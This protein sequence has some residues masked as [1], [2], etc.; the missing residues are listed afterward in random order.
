M[1]GGS[2]PASGRQRAPLGSFAFGKTDQSVARHDDGR[3]AVGL[4]PELRAMLPGPFV[5]GREIVF[6]DQ[7]GKSLAP[8]VADGKG[9]VAD[10]AG[11]GG[12]VRS[13]VIAAALLELRQEV[14]GP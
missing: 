3:I 13:E 14:G 7:F 2:G 5:N 11:Q 8:V 10:V 12:K 9:L 1:A 4:R 6:I